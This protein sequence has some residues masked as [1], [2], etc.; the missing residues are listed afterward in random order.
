M[1]VIIDSREGENSLMMPLLKICCPGITRVFMSISVTGFI[2][3]TKL[4][5]AAWPGTL[6]GPVFHK[7]ECVMCRIKILNWFALIQNEKK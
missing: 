4:V 1:Q 5:L 7:S 3:P 2:L 6:S